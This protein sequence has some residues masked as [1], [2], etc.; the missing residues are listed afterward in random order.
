VGPEELG[1][2]GPAVWGTRRSLPVVPLIGDQRYYGEAPV[3]LPGGSGAG[4]EELGARGPA[5]WGTKL[6]LDG[7]PRCGK[8]ATSRTS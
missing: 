8:R 6:G 7:S 1:A 5:V 2:G 3:R 4:P